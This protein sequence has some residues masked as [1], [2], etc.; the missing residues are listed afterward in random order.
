[1]TIMIFK[2][3]SRPLKEEY[4]SLNDYEEFKTLSDKEMKFGWYFSCKDSPFI[5]LEQDERI[6]RILSLKLLEFSDSER[7]KYMN[8]KLSDEV[9]ASFA[10]WEKFIP[11]IRE[12]GKKI[13]DAIIANC[14]KVSAQD[15][16]KYLNT[17]PGDAKSFMDASIN[18]AKNLP[19][20]IRV[21]EQGF[22]VTKKK[23]DVV[24]TKETDFELADEN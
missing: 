19:E 5:H 21:A 18:I 6:G 16:D 4:E 10:L 2:P 12:R 15:V 11:H 24:V 8:L 23:S 22:G 1:M 14:E 7:N 3:S 13:I 17:D 20:M 9:I